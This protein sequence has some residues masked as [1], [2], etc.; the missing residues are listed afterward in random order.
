MVDVLLNPINFD[1][2]ENISK[3]VSI[4]FDSKELNKVKVYPTLVKDALFVEL[5]NDSKA[6]IAVRDLTGRV[7]LTQNTEGVSNTTLNLGAFANG[8][9]I[10]SVR[11]N[12]AIETV[13]IYKQ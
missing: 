3:T 10:L 8:L 7:I 5:S 1:G 13:K 6:E 9:Y 2:A 12:E 4:N 11:S